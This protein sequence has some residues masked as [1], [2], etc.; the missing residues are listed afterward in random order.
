MNSFRQIVVAAV[1]LFCAAFSARAQ[2]V[3]HVDA[4]AQT[5]WFTGSDS[6]TTP[7]VGPPSAW[8]GW[9]VGSFS[10]S[11]NSVSLSLFSF[12]NAQPTSFDIG[13][14]S[15]SFYVRFTYTD[16][17]AAATIDG[18]GSGTTYNYSSWSAGEIATL[19]G[20]SSLSSTDSM[21]GWKSMTV[22]VTGAAVPEPSTYALL[23]GVSALAGVIFLRRRRAAV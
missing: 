3:M 11:Y 14:D 22:S 13:V 9:Q 6:G 8:V 18:V 7:P 23:M 16:R 2:L 5:L 21:S 17:S 19:E 10:G 20:L 1:V 15:S 4:T 12:S